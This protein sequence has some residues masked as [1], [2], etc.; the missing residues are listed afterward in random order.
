MNKTDLIAGGRVFPDSA[1]EDDQWVLNNIGL[2]WWQRIESISQF[3]RLHMAVNVH[4]ERNC[5]MPCQ[6]LCFRRMDASTGERG[7][8]RVTEGMEVDASAIVVFVFDVR[9]PKIGAKH[10]DGV[11]A[12]VIRPRT[13]PKQSVSF[14]AQPRTETFDKRNVK[15]K[16]V[17]PSSFAVS[18]F[19]G[20][21]LR[22]EIERRLRE[23]SQFRSTQT[24]IRCNKVEHGPILRI[25]AAQTLT[26]FGGRFDE[27]ME[28]L[29]CERSPLSFSIY[30]SVQETEGRKR[31]VCRPSLRPEPTGESFDRSRIVITRFDADWLSLPVMPL[32]KCF[33]NPTRFEIGERLRFRSV[34]QITKT[35]HR[36]RNVTLRV[37]LRSKIHLVVAYVFTDRTP[38]FTGVSIHTHGPLTI[39]VRLQASEKRFRSLTVF[40]QRDLLSFAVCGSERP[41]EP[42]GYDRTSFRSQCLFRTLFPVCVYVLRGFLSPDVHCL[43][44]REK[45]IESDQ[46]WRL[47]APYL[48]GC[49]HKTPC[50]HEKTLNGEPLSVDVNH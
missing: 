14:L 35:V 10:L 26:A 29:G 18:G 1:T 33:R 24:G 46:R 15:R 37:C 50:G 44:L 22:F 47:S 30:V 38:A 5:G 2:Q 45:W 27:A 42:F 40:G 6:F 31:I 39:F 34:Q 19:D 9:S 25:E 21:C 43:R 13:M 16:R 28:F 11:G 7:D 23:R 32:G 41:I 8:E 3:F 4:C 49:P 20:N 17:V 48:H 36:E 12:A